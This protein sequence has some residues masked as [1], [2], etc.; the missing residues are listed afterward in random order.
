MGH[1]YEE[2]LM[3]YMRKWDRLYLSC[4]A[5]APRYMDPALVRVHEHVDLPGA[6]ALG[7]RRPVVPDA[8]LPRGGQGACRS[9]TSAMALFLGGTARRLLSRSGS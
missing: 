7:E 5:Y 3:N 2:L 9:T 6:G 4:T 1:P 8:A